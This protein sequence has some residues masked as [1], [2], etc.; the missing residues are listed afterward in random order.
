MK[1]ENLFSIQYTY[2]HKLYM[3]FYGVVCGSMCVQFCSF[4]LFIFISGLYFF[5]YQNVFLLLFTQEFRKIKLFVGLS[6][7]RISKY[8]YR[9]ICL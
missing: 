2:I 8:M 6:I 1:K 4:I 3:I 9:G 7:C 5:I